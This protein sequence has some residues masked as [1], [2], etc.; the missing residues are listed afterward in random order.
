MR[1]TAVFF[2]LAA[3]SIG[4]FGFLIAHHWID[5]RAAE[6]RVRDRL[7][8]LKKI[9]DQPAESARLVIDLLREEDAREEQRARRRR[10]KARR[11][12]MQGGA[13]VVAAGVGV[14]I[15]LA[16]IAPRGIWTVG[17][18]P[19]LVGVVLFTFAYFS[20]SLDSRD[21]AVAGS[22]NPRD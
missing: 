14:S 5:A 2:F 7:A 19:A 12:D 22:G 4:L 13:L 18:I 15:M 9:A 17:L 21:S 11:D 8:L 1:H 20:K 10:Q 16:A 6:R 3:A